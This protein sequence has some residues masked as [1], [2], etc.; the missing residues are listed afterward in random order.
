M[1]LRTSQSQIPSCWPPQAMTN[2][3]SAAR[4]VRLAS[5]ISDLARSRSAKKRS[6][7]RMESAE[8]G[9]VR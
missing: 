6:L 4:S 1:R 7:V 5:R 9:S 3:S 8:T 2:R